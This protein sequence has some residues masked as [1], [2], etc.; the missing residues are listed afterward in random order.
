MVWRRVFSV[1]LAWMTVILVVVKAGVNADGSLTRLADG[2][3]N[4]CSPEIRA[5]AR[6]R[7]VSCWRQSSSDLDLAFK[8]CFE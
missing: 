2:W 8:R 3:I 5:A 7:L 4:G 1:A 6:E